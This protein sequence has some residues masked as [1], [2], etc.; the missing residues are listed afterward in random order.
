MTES[1]PVIEPGW[2]DPDDAPEWTDEMFDRAELSTGGKVVRAASGALTTDVLRRSRL[3]AIQLPISM[4]PGP[5]TSRVYAQAKGT[6]MTDK[7]T[8][9][10]AA[11]AASKVMK[12]GRTGADSKTAAGSALSQKEKGGKKK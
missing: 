1:K 11:K 7:K 2:V 6:P 12:D 4:K 9:P 5:V 8:S 3:S 10:K